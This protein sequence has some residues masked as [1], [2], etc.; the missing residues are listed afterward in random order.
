[1]FTSSQYCLFTFSSVLTVRKALYDFCNLNNY[2]IK[3]V[4]DDFLKKLLLESVLHKSL[5]VENN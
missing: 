3:L 5:N 1:M 4:Y 2:N